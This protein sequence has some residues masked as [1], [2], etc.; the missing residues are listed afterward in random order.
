MIHHLQKNL[1]TLSHI[2]I[3]KIPLNAKMP[4]HIIIIFHYPEDKAAT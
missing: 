4:Y 2:I 1:S 3:H